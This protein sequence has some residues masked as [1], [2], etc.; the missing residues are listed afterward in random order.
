LDYIIAHAAHV[1]R[2][3]AGCPEAGLG[4]HIFRR[5]QPGIVTKRLKLPT[6]MNFGV[7][8]PSARLAQR[9]PAVRV[10]PDPIFVRDGRVWTSAG[11]T[12]GIDLALALVEEYT[13]GRRSGRQTKGA[14]SHLPG[15]VIVLCHS[16]FSG[17]CFPLVALLGLYERGGN[18]L[19]PLHV[20]V[21]A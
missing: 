11:V 1:H 20:C 5:H 10:E 4:A 9:F 6:E 3:P 17:L 8:A 19:R 21:S 13:S 15:V 18:A 16:P 12:A 2:T 7:D 14:A